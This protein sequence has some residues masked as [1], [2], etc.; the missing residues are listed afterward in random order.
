MFAKIDP[1]KQTVNSYKNHEFIPPHRKTKLE[2]HTHRHGQQEI[3]PHFIT[4]KQHL[5]DK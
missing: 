3:R 1:I 5:N 2:R 4:I